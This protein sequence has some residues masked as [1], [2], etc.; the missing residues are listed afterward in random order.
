VSG[1]LY[2]LG[3]GLACRVSFRLR[4]SGKVPGTNS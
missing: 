2:G 4:V 1:L 3:I